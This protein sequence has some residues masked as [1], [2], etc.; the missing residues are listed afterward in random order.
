MNPD[1]ERLSETPDVAGAYPRLSGEQI[2]IWTAAIPGRERQEG[3][4]GQ[5]GREGQE[6]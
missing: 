3:Q 1:E 4:E 2:E 6:R 5:E